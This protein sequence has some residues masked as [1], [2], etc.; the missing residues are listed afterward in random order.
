MTFDDFHNPKRITQSMRNLGL[1]SLTFFSFN[2]ERVLEQ[3]MP[4]FLNRDIL[5]VAGFA[6]PNPV[7]NEYPKTN[8]PPN[9]A[10]MALKTPPYFI[11]DS[12]T[13]IVDGDFIKKL[14]SDYDFMDYGYRLIIGLK[15]QKKSFLERAMAWIKGLFI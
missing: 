5:D 7:D 13:D 12:Y 9:H 2:Y 1:E 4:T 3:D 10:F 14:A 8:Y 11:F 6:W 15:S